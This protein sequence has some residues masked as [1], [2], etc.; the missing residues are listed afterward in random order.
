M[1]TILEVRLSPNFA[2]SILLSLVEFRSGGATQ[3]IALDA[4]NGTTTFG[5]R[6]DFNPSCDILSPKKRLEN[7][8][9]LGSYGFYPE[10][11]LAKLAPRSS[12]VKV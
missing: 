2:L 5:G 9:L 1:A 11:L 8:L 7:T 3:H 6:N 10:Q 12:L 4:S